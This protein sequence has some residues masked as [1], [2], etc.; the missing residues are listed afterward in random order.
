MR[1]PAAIVWSADRSVRESPSAGAGSSS[2]NRRSAGARNGRC[3]VSRVAH[4]ASV[5][6]SGAWRAAQ[7]LAAARSAPGAARRREGQSVSSSL[8][9]SSPRPANDGLPGKEPMTISSGA[10]SALC[11]SARTSRSWSWSYRSCSNQSTT[12]RPSRSASSSCRS[13]RSSEERSACWRPQPQSARKRARVRSSSCRGSAGTGPS[14]S[15]SCQGRTA[16]PSAVCRSVLPALSPLV[17]WRSE[18]RAAGAP[19]RRAR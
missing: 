11:A 15:T 3:A 9:V 13:R 10:A 14:W 1:A 18:G 8:A 5:V 6:G 19:P 12:W 17:T 4:S 2:S 7:A 16:P